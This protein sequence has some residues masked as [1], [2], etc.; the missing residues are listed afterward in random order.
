[1]S[2]EWKNL[3]WFEH[4][5]KVD[6]VFERFIKLGLSGKWRLWIKKFNEKC[7]VRLMESRFFIKESKFIHYHQ[8]RS[9]PTKSVDPFDCNFAKFVNKF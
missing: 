6:Q 9:F 8:R 2:D 5:E 4:K 7:A 1:M 3:D